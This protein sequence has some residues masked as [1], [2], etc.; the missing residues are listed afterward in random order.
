MNH[1]RAAGLKVGQLMNFNYYPGVE[2]ERF[3]I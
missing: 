2:H 3:V 1:L